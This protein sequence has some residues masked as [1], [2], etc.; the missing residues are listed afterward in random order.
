M[1]SR[2]T[3]KI[4]EK[5]TN[6]LVLD[7]G[8]MGY[9]VLIP[10]CVMQRIDESCGSDGKITL[11]TY[12]YYQVDQAKSLPILIGFL[13]QVEKDFFEVFIT[14]SGIGPRAALR[15]LNKPISSIARAIDE[16]DLVFL[17]SLP[18]I[19]EQRAKEIVAKLQNKVGKFGLIQDR[20]MQVKSAAKDISEEALDVLL[21]LEYKRA[22]ATSM[23]KKVLESNTQV[24]TTE[25]L[26]NLVYKQRRLK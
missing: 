5:G 18:G 16:G 6:C 14:V 11:L 7:L 25:E 8:G 1:I 9:D 15:A 2:I 4:S 12:H 26:L 3:G 17:K 22:E 19:G 20:D 13:S 23:I 10:A 24:V 21:Q